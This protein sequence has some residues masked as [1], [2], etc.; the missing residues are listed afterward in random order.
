MGCGSSF[1]KEVKRGTRKAKKIA[2]S[3][4]TGYQVG[5]GMGASVGA[6]ESSGAAREVDKL[7][8]G[9]LGEYAEIATGGVIQSEKTKS[10]IAEGRRAEAEQQME[11][12]RIAAGQ[13]KKDEKRRQRTAAQKK[14]R[15]SLLWSGGSELGV[16]GKAL[17]TKL[18]G[19]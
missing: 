3:S 10:L 11:I 8:G 7:S 2:K 12:E 16:V 5:G 4:G 14:G 18:G 1:K 9:K 13:A 19:N 17:S 6:A 15:R